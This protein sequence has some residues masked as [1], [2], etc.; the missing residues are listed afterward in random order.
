MGQGKA[1]GVEPLEQEGKLY[2]G[3]RVQQNGE[4][5]ANGPFL[6]DTRDLTTH[7]VCVGMTGSGKTGLGIVLLEEAALHGIPALIV[8]PKG[9]MTN[10]VLNF[11]G[12]S[13]EDFRPWVDVEGARRRGVSIDEYAQE[14]AQSWR[15]GLAQWGI[16]G[17]RIEHLRGRSRFVIYTPGSDAGYPV[18]IVQSLQRPD[19]SWDREAEVLRDTISSIVS[20]ILALVNV[21]SDPVTGREHTLLATLIERAWQSGQDMDLAQLITQVQKPPFDRLGVLPLE[22]FYPEK[23]RL[24]LTL[25]LNG[26]LASP[27][28]AQWLEGDPL[29]VNTLLHSPDGLPQMSILHLAHLSDSE[30]TFF[31]TLLLEQVRAWLRKQE[32]TTD[33]RAI[34]YIDELYGFM[35]PHPANPPTKA[36]LLTL[37]KQAR[38]QGLGLVLSTQNPL[39]LD[40]KGLSNAGTWF[41]GK[42]QTANDRNR[43]LEGL[44]GASLEVGVPLDAGAVGEII[45]RL[46]ARTFFV[47]NVHA[48]GPVLLRTR[49]AMSYLRGPLS[50]DQIRQWKEG[51]REVLRARV[52]VASQAVPPARP[53]ETPARLAAAPSPWGDLTPQPP[54]LPSDIRQFYLPARVS[55]EWAIRNA[56]QDGRTIIYRDK[57]LVYRPALMGRATVRVDNEAYGVHEQRAVVRV[58]SVPENEPFVSWSAQPIVT[59]VRDLDDQPAQGARFAPLPSLL[60]DVRR[61]KAMERDFADYVYRETTITLSRHRALKLTARPDES[62]G[63]FKRRCYQVIE[64]GRDEEIRGLEKRYQARI[65]RLEERIRREGR[66]LEQ[67]QAEYQARKREEVISAGESVLDWLSR[68]RSSRALSTASRKRRLTEQ[69]K[70][71]V[72]ESW[73]SIE[74][75]Q[76][77]RQELVGQMEAEKSE[78]QSRWSETADDLDT[79]QLRP[80]KTDVFV[81]ACGVMWMPYWDVLF[82]EDGGKERLLSLPA[83]ESGA[84]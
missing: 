40:Y 46:E 66:E 23:E 43:V 32:G 61:L 69:S 50:R 79:V 1:S 77:Q 7:A 38:S 72:R 41:V 54:V 37:L 64:Q 56:E 52:A 82:D 34:L 8:D 55:L 78:I 44:A 80:R 57:Q 76:T 19:L 39:D 29:R 33:L 30:R 73:E 84:E 21:E 62:L 14:V 45:G 9:D 58:L 3:R 83:Y 75:L 70:A 28:F 26:L 36:A 20:A 12:L 18:S 67:D 11:L 68:R 74:D 63:Q 31:M 71:E 27:R 16:D 10:L 47:N 17:S 51:Q 42:L 81:E 13:P 53:A 59:Q 48:A 35:P 2:L 5:L 60:S 22:V 15:E 25:A 4:V 6:Y 49:H 24:S 65:E